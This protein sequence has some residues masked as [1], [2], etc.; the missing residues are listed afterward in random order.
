MNFDSFSPETAKPVH[1]E[2]DRAVVQ[3]VKVEDDAAR[4]TTFVNLFQHPGFSESHPR[5][6]HFV[7]MYVAAG[8]GDGGAV[9]LV[10]DIYSS[11][12]IAFG[13]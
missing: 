1:I 2:F 12:T 11:E 10:T 3:A 6:D 9:R 4:K 13:L 8:A 7:P 5:A